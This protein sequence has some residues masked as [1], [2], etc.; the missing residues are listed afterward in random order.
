M[1]KRLAF[2]DLR[3]AT[4]NWSENF[5]FTRG[6]DVPSGDKPA[7]GATPYM[8][9]DEVR[10]RLGDGSFGGPYQAPDEVMQK[11]FEVAVVEVVQLLTGL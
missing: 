11:L 8:P 2:C 6:A 7:T 10:A 4:C 5:P 3:L 9:A 1:T